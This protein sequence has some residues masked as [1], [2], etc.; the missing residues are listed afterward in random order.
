MNSKL[1]LVTGG[2]GFIGKHLVAK[3]IEKGYKV[4]VLDLVPP[5]HPAVSFFK[6]SIL[7][8]ELVRQ[9]VEGAECVFHLAA[10]PH[11]WSLRKVDFHEVNVE[12]TKRVLTIAAE[13]SVPKI[14]HTSTEAILGTYRSPA[15]YLINEQTA[16]PPLSQMPGPY[17]ASKRKA[18]EIALKLIYRKAPIIRVYPTTP[19]GAG[20]E[21]FTAPTQMIYD[22]MSG[23]HP[24]YLECY[25]N[26]VSVRDVAN[27]MLLAME[28]GTVGERYIL[29]GENL[30]F[31][32][33]LQILKEEFH[34]HIPQIQ[35]PYF[36]ALMTAK[37]SG[38]IAKFITHKAP[39][40]SLEGV[41][42]AAANLR[43]DSTKAIQE[44]GMPQTNAREGI[45]ETVNWLIEKGHL[46]ISKENM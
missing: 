24:A 8:Q 34:I 9:A 5:A 38:V 41:R 36:V 7:D 17:T 37:V 42:L 21:N 18:E 16:I 10:N 27:G 19:L 35:I 1:C 4:N 25:L 2:S 43:F 46:S 6:G 3:L 20:D 44:L 28:K 22:F 32:E 45:K 33:I 13:E 31:S 26:L 14:I 29:G 39:A 23:K 12:G 30:K 40:A 15:R 11:L